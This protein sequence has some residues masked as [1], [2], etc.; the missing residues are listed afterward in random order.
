[1][2]VRSVDPRRI[3][4]GQWLKRKREEAGLTLLDVSKL[5]GIKYY[6]SISNL[7]HGV[8]R[9]PPSRYR[10]FALALKMD[11]KEFASELLRHYHPELYKMLFG[12]DG[13][14]VSRGGRPADDTRRRKVGS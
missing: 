8:G 5:L 4:G 9:I 14:D 10:D 2:P 13:R 3:A 7:E 11:E 12:G 6:S 1:M